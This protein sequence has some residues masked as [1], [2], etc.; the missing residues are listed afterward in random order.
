MQDLTRLSAIVNL[1]KLELV[2]IES[3]TFVIL[4]LS[5]NIYICINRK[6]NKSKNNLFVY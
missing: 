5:L 2:L 6:K 3:N 1:K 4:F